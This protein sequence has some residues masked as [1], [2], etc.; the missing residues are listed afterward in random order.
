MKNNQKEEEQE[1]N[2]VPSNSLVLETANDLESELAKFRKEWKD[3][4][5]KQDTQQQQVPQQSNEPSSNEVFKSKNI[6]QY[7]QFPIRNRPQVA[8][9]SNQET[10]EDS[11]L[12]YEKPQN[13][14]QKAQYLFNKG[15]LLEQQGRHFEGKIK[16]TQ[17]NLSKN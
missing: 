16:L 12:V 13:N 5:N 10:N 14:E 1:D 8:Q 11:G 2:I 3:E 4:L 6:A 17:N 9:Q 7:H 15:V